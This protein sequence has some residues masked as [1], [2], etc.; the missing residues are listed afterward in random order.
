M[1]VCAP[2]KGKGQAMKH[3]P[4]HSRRSG[5]ARQLIVTILV[6]LMLIGLYFALG[7]LFD[8]FTSLIMG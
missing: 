3:K 1:D 6:V 2:D 8:D 4:P 5:S 7:A